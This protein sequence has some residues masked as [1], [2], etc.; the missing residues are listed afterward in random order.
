MHFVTEVGQF[1]FSYP[2]LTEGQVLD[3]SYFWGGRS[4]CKREFL[5]EHG[6][7]NPIFR[8]GCEDIE[9]AFR[10]SAFGLRVVYN[11]RAISTIVRGFTFDGFCRRLTRQGRSNFVFNS[12]YDDASVRRWTEVESAQ[13]EWGVVAPVADALLRS[14]RRVDEAF[15]LKMALGLAGDVDRRVLYDTYWTAFRVSKIHGIVEMAKESNRVQGGTSMGTSNLQG[16]P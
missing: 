3:F 6:V 4:S 15:R 13:T 10:L 2:N 9:L 11:P 12:L 1:L 14:A 8:F 5:L 16:A 7:F